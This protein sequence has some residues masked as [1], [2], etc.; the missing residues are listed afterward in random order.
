MLHRIGRKIFRKLC[1][2]IG[3]APE[4]QIAGF[5]KRQAALF[6]GSRL[7]LKCRMQQRCQIG[8]VFHRRGSSAFELCK[9]EYACDHLVDMRDILHD[10]VSVFVRI[11]R[12]HMRTEIFRIAVDHGERRF[13]IVGERTG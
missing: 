5:F 8:V 7:A 10:A 4:R 1:Q 11:L 6:H 3:I 12:M 9:S 13:Q 2:H